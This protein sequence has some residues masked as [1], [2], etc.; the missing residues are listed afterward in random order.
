[1]TSPST[2][3]VD[4]VGPPVSA[5]WLNGVNNTAYPPNVMVASLPSVSTVPFG[6]RQMVTDATATTFASIVA[7]GGSNVVPVYSDGTH[8]RIG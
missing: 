3:Y 2:T 7:G 6:Y 8:W 5:S 4:L 1:M